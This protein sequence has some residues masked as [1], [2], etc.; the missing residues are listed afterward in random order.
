LKAD[1][2]RVV[3]FVSFD[4]V[5]RIL[6]PPSIGY[7]LLAVLYVCSHES[8]LQKAAERALPGPLE[9]GSWFGARR[10]H[11]DITQLP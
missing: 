10:Q 1:R 3:S 4:L 2:E 9:R 11:D 5:G 7:V 6:R 8:E